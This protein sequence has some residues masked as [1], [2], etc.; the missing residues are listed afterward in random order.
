MLSEGKPNVDNITSILQKATSHG[1]DG[2]KY[3][4]LMIKVLTK[5]GFST[6]EVIPTFKNLFEHKKL[7]NC[8]SSI[9]IIGY[10]PYYWSFT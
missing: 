1:S 6:K 7:A 8:M 4:F 9:L 3:L 10:P 5:E 2:A